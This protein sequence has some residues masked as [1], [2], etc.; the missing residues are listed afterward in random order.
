MGYFFRRARLL[1]RFN[2]MSFTFS[3]ILFF[4]Y[5]FVFVSVLWMKWRS[6]LVVEILLLKKTFYLGFGSVFCSSISFFFPS[7]S[8]WDFSLF[9]SP[10]DLISS[11]IQYSIYSGNT[12]LDFV[13]FLWWFCM[14]MSRMEKWRRWQW[15][16][17]TDINVLEDNELVQVLWVTR[18]SLHLPST[19]Y[20]SSSPHNLY[21]TDYHLRHNHA[22]HEAPAV[23]SSFN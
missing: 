21:A 8:L 10:L 1:Q 14:E 3:S 7:H 6:Y 18:L 13:I 15:L 5:V 11:F 20:P 4:C 16:N 19:P 22:I 17:T 9:F 12:F 2:G 23:T